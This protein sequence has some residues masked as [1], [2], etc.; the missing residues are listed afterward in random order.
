MPIVSATPLLKSDAL[1][2][3]QLLFK[4]LSLTY[5]QICQ[6]NISIFSCPRQPFDILLSSSPQSNHAAALHLLHLA[7]IKLT[8]LHSRMFSYPFLRHPP[9]SQGHIYAPSSNKKQLQDK[10]ITDI[11]SK[12]VEPGFHTAGFFQPIVPIRILAKI[13]CM[14]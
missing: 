12:V 14:C 1:S 9:L 3:H 6:Y 4:R 5:H 10:M 7:S 8:G 11:E 13:S 2:K